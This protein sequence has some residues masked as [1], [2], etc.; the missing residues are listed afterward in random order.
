MTTENEAGT[1]GAASAAGAASEA[2]DV[3]L[4]TVSSCNVALSAWVLQLVV[5]DA[6]PGAAGS[7]AKENPRMVIGIPWPLAKVV[8]QMMGAAIAAYEKQEGTISVPR[9]IQAQID[10]QLSATLKA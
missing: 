9:S 6:V 4:V 1:G 3:A 8:H 5:G 7:N 10:K 2:H